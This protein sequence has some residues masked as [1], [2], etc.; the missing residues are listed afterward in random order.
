M[1]W[2]SILDYTLGT[3]NG[4]DGC[5]AVSG[6]LS[7]GGSV[8]VDVTP[9]GLWGPGTYVLATAA[10]GIVNNSNQLTGWTLVGT[11]LGN[12][13][14]TL[15]ISGNSLDLVVGPAAAVSGTWTAA[16]G[17]SWSTTGQLGG[18]QH[19]HHRRRHGRLRRC[20]HRGPIGH[21]HHG[22]QPH[23]EPLAFSTSGGGNYTISGGIGGTLSLYNDA[24]AFAVSISGGNQ[25]IAVP[26]A[27]DGNLAVTAAAGSSLTFS[28][29]ISG[30]GKAICFSGGGI[31]VLSGS[32]SYTGSM[33]VHGG[34]LDFAGPAAS[35]HR[36]HRQR[37]PPG[38]R[39]FDE[40]AGVLCAPRWLT[41][42]W[43]KPLWP[44]RRATRLSGW[45]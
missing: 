14:H 24:S 11:F 4:A 21:R 41:R 27:V 3:A 22:R 33:T 15:A 5:L 26:V 31:L 13:S 9:G 32:D 35:P 37:R 7:L 28:G 6:S 16:G 17:G 39:G 20:R 30:T 8:T 23:A 36:Q 10:R 34:T 38:E 19:A 43:R 44:P 1:D 25:T 42:A 18:Q 40:P 2:T 12:G 29:P 45:A